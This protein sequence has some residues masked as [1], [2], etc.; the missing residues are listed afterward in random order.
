MDGVGG[1][2][3]EAE[4][5]IG[6]LIVTSARGDREG[7]ARLYDLGAPRVLGI[8]G[9][10]VH[11]PD[12]AQAVLRDV[13]LEAWRT[14]AGFDPV[15]SSGRAWLLA[16][17]HRRAVDERGPRASAELL[18]A[19]EPRVHGRRLARALVALSDEQ[20]VALTHA[21]FGGRSEAEIAALTG[22]TAETVRA[23]LRDGL[24]RVRSELG[25]AS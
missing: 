2:G 21:Y 11:D 20:R 19:A 5:R 25:A 18:D 15:E 24:S 13:F 8:V 3:D 6:M 7:F 23:R 16:I 17:A 4:D 10:I 14:A 22:A 1:P 9:R 12:R